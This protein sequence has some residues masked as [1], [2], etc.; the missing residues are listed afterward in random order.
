MSDIELKHHN[1][2]VLFTQALADLLFFDDWGDKL[3]TEAEVQCGFAEG[4]HRI[5]F[6]NGIIEIIDFL[7]NQYDQKM[8]KL[9]AEHEVPIKIKDRIAL[10]L[11]IRIKNYVP[12]LVHLKNSIYYARPTNTISAIK[13]ALRTCN[14]IWRYAGDRSTDHNYYTKRSL[15]LGVYVTSI[16]YYLQDDSENSVETDQYIIESLS[17]IVNITSKFKSIFTLPKLVDLPII[18]LFS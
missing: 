3:L 14:L 5:I 1:L 2:K 18:R 17:D 15:L 11:K 10:A 16:I 4:Y 6:P 8:L 9:L 7:E 12:K 13:I